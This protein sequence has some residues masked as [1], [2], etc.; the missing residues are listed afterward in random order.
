MFRVNPYFFFD[1][2][3]QTG[4]D[5]FHAEFENQSS[6]T[7][8]MLDLRVTQGPGRGMTVTYN[9][10][11]KKRTVFTIEPTPEGSRMIITDD[12]DLLPAAERERRQSEVDKSLKA[13]AESLRLYFLRLKRW[14]WLPGWR[15]YLRRVWIPMKPS[16]RRIVWL[17]YLITVAEFFFFLFVLLI[18]L[19]EQKN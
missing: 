1:E 16:A 8:Q 5:A 2:W 15:W 10:G 6:Q 3:R 11:I 9:G 7:R 19:I 14:S 18:Y 12:Y 17:I 13:W 4:P